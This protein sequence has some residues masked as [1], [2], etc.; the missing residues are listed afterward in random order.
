[1]NQKEFCEIVDDLESDKKFKEQQKRVWE[2]N[3]VKDKLEILSDICRDYDVYDICWKVLS[4]ERFSRCSAAAN[5]GHQSYGG[6]LLEHT[7][8]V[9]DSGLLLSDYY[10][11]NEYEQKV[12]IVSGIW[13]DYGKCWDYE[14][15]LVEISENDGD[16]IWSKKVW[17]RTEHYKLIYHLS[18]SNMEFYKENSNRCDEKFVTDVSHCILSHH[19]LRE[20]RSPVSPN[21]KSAWLLHMMD[22][23]NA[24]LNG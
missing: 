20:W 5:G 24:K 11:F 14:E 3:T 10:E 4:D 17:E 18:R 12:F 19:Q 1:M 7:Y 13:H 6:G 8:D 9:V 21:S 23:L 15:K 22:N 2:K 16:I